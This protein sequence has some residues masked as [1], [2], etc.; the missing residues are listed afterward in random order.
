MSLK[1]IAKIAPFNGNALLDVNASSDSILNKFK[2]NWLVSK[3]A[4]KTSQV[5]NKLAPDWSV[6]RIDSLLFAPQNRKSAPVQTPKGFKSEAIRTND[7]EVH[8][9]TTGSGPLVIFFHGWGGSASQFIPLMSGLARCGFSALAIDHLG[10]GLSKAKPT[11]LR[12]SIDTTNAVIQHVRK[13]SNEGLAAIVG[14]STGCIAIANARPTLINEIPLF[15]ISP[16]FNYKLFFLKRLV[17]LKLHPEVVRQY[18][19]RF[20]KTFKLNYG[21]FDLATRLTKYADAATIAHDEC[22][23]ESSVSGSVKFCQQNPLTRLLV[24]KKLDHNRIVNSESVWQELKTTVNYDD[25]T[26]NF[27]EVVFQ[28]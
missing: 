14:H 4:R 17:K 12:Q 27:L 9:L 16:V 2:L 11:T 28:R 8:A 23:T 10:H 19:S 5:Q 3:M 22:D 7:G 21:K 24:T 25:T 18:A 20:G 6:N 15:L 26:I 13:N 1:S